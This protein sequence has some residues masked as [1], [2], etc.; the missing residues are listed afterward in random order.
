M[1][2]LDEQFLVEE[3]K[4]VRV[5]QEMFERRYHQHL[6]F[7][8]TGIC[9]VLGFS[10]KMP[11]ITIPVII[12]QILVI[13]SSISLSDRGLSQF[14]VAF[15][16]C[17]YNGKN[18]VMCFEDVFHE[19]FRSDNEQRKVGRCFLTNPFTMLNTFGVFVNFF[20]AYKS[21]PE[22]KIAYIGIPYIAL[23]V[24][25]HLWIFAN[26]L[27]TVRISYF[28]VEENVRTALEHTKTRTEG[29]I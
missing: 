9:A 26:V 10:E 11:S 6:T 25:S 14:C 29:A 24:A 2:N 1:T 3:Y 12:S 23:L 7:C 4:Q 8:V 5:R 20:F 16:R 15:L 17:K 19:L 21:W 22:L 13:T 28:S 18:K 27:K